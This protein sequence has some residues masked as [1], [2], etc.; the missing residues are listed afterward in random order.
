MVFLLA[1][2]PSDIVE[3][4]GALENEAFRSIEFVKAIVFKFIEQTKGE[5]SNLEGVAGFKTA[6]FRQF[7]DVG[8]VFF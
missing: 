6:V 5:S 1:F 2:D 7:H 3:Q 8:K 4:G